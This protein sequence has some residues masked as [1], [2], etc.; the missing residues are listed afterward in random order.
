MQAEN[1]FEELRAS[2]SLWYANVKGSIVFRKGYAGEC[3]IT[4]KGDVVNVFPASIGIT[5]LLKIR[6][7]ALCLEFFD[8]EYIFLLWQNYHLNDDFDWTIQMHTCKF[9]L[10]F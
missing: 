1:V 5:V 8:D 10:S 9:S 2:S 6:L 3:N 7:H 4:V